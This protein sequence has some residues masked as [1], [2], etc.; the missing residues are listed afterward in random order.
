MVRK[1]SYLGVKHDSELGNT[2]RY[3]MSFIKKSL[4]QLD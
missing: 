1:L 2:G 4:M 3:L